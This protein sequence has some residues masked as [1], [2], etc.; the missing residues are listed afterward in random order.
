MESTTLHILSPNHRSQSPREL[1]ISESQD[2]AY[3]GEE[4][5]DTELP[6]GPRLLCTQIRV[7]SPRDPGCLEPLRQEQDEAGL[8]SFSPGAMVELQVSLSEQ[9]LED[10][11]CT[12]LGSARGI[13]GVFTTT[14]ATE[15]LHTT[16]HSLHVP[17]PARE[18]LSQHGV[19]LSSPSMLGQVEVTLQQHPAK[20]GA[21]AGWG[22]LTVGEGEGAGGRRA[23]GSVVS[24]GEGGG[25]HSE[26][27]PASFTVSFGVPSEGASPQE[28]LD[29]DS[30]GD[31]GKP[32]K[33]RARHASKYLPTISIFTIDLSNLTT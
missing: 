28:E 2:E 32:N 1:Y 14:E 8:A 30:E 5:S 24:Q 4:E 25:G 3:Y 21:G 17:A 16:T 26:G 23:S 27:A 22:I 29:S 15:S 33:H 11:G 7:P 19:V 31:R 20:S 9:S 13:E 18:P 12:S 10:M 6:R